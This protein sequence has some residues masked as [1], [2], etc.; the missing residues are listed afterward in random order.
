MKPL[1]WTTF[2]II[3]FLGFLYFSTMGWMWST[4]CSV[5]SNTLTACYIK[6]QSYIV[7]AFILFFLAIG[8][9]ICAWLE[10]KRN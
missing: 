10:K 8:F 4:N 3:F 2:G 1:Q 7:P 6:T 9:V 5:S